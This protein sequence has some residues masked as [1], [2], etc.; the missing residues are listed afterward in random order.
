MQDNIKKGSKRCKIYQVKE[1]EEL[2]LWSKKFNFSITTSSILL[3]AGLLFETFL[4]QKVLAQIMFLLVVVFV[5]YPIIKEGILSLVKKQITINLLISIAAT[6]AFLIGH[7]E[8]G[9]AVM[10]LFF[11]AESLERYAEE[12]TK[13]SILSLIESAPDKARIKEGRQEKEIEVEKVKVGS[14][15]VVR[16]GDKIP[17]DGIVVYGSS[18][19]NQAP[20][21]GESMPVLKKEGDEVFA[22][23]IVEEG[24][25]E[26]RVTKPSNKTT[27]ARM[28]ELVERA[29]KEKSTTERFVERF[30]KFYTPSVITF[31]LVVATV[32]PFIFSMPFL[33]WVYRALVL[34]VISCPCALAISTPVSMISAIT[35]AAR[36]GIL[37][38]G[39]SY[40]EEIR[41]VKAVAFDKTGTLTLGK[42]K[43]VEVY[44]LNGYSPQQILKI[45]SS[46]ESLSKHPL[47]QAILKK[48]RKENI[49]PVKV[50]NFKSIIGK[51]VKGKIGREYYYIGNKNLFPENE[52]ELPSEI[53]RFESEGKTVIFVGNKR[54]IV[55]I[56]T[57]MD[58]IREDADKLM[59]KLK[60]KGIVTVMLTGDNR[61][62]ACATSGKIGVDMHYA[63]LLPH[64]KVEIIDRLLAKFEHVA[65]VGDGVNDAPALAKA[66]V[67]IAMGAAGSDIAIETADVALMK[68]DLLEVD[69]LIELSKK[70]MRIVKQ[71]IFL[72]II[73][74]GTFAALAF[75]G[76][77][78]LWLAVAVGDMGLS[79]AVILNALRIAERYPCSK[80]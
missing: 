17:L 73:V 37:V 43:V 2:S 20:I 28:I 60:K 4:K 18:S 8:E 29:R 22:G 48:A 36:K 54:K 70:T 75:P 9:A 71:N 58:E 13:K 55:G 63:E 76:M 27:L 42:P 61:S 26:F 23:S 24:Y 53:G 78:S 1:R 12:R 47:A 50:E 64:Q 68:D 34:L 30:A 49:K 80:K 6:G 41:K 72:S 46:L 39:G 10:F 69:Y 59:K 38:K 32:P 62:V 51:G 65:M 74:K 3:I 11:L 31:A 33:P 21:T 57:L 15:A 19:V 67:G 7:G 77:I 40:I 79:L 35:A 45:A 14:I 25:L 16:A 56:I 5:G 66:C 52:V 44:G